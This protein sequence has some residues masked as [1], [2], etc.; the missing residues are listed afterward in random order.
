MQKVGLFSADFHQWLVE[1][2]TKFIGMDPK[3]D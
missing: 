3:A 2:V 1:V